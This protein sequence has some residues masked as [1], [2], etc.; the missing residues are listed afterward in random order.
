[1]KQH[2]KTIIETIGIA[3]A[4][5]ILSLLAAWAAI[6]LLL[7]GQLQFAVVA[8]VVAF[9][10]DSFDGFLARKLGKASEFGRQLDGMIDAFNYSLF[11][12]LLVQQILLPGVLGFITG[13][14]I[15][16]FGILRLVGFNT[17]GYLK[18]GKKLYYEG[19]VTCHLSLSAIIFVFLDQFLTIPSWVVAGILIILSILQLSTIRTPKT[20]ALLFWIPVAILIAI[21]SFIW[22]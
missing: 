21:G 10:L 15:L 19:V 20:G 9:L 13:F 8:A 2:V 12:A 6:C 5:S 18:R 16:A 17:N 14:F 7:A 3:G 11:A 1:M 4:V 22:L